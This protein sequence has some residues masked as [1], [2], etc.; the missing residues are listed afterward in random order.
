MSHVARLSFVVLA[1]LMFALPAFGEDPYSREMY[2]A[3][4][5]DE[6]PLKMKHIVVHPGEGKDRATMGGRS[7]LPWFW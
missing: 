4:Y 1:A 5:S 2:T 7:Q 3:P 6:T